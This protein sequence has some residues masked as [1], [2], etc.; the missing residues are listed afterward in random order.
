MIY[1]CIYIY[2]KYTNVHGKG[3]I[4]FRKGNKS[5]IVGTWQLGFTL[6]YIL[7]QLALKIENK[8]NCN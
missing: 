8:R 6:I 3:Q 1:I 2:N 4:E 5:N 7:R